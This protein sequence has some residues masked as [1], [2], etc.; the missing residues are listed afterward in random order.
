MYNNRTKDVILCKMLHKHIE[1][2][3]FASNNVLHQ[4]SILKFFL[5]ISPG[6]S[7]SLTIRP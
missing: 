6:T 2:G 1:L 4:F 3:D 7:G 5:Q